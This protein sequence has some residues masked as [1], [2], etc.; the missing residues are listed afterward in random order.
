[1]V[2][3]HVSVLGVRDEPVLLRFLEGR[4]DTTMF[5]RANL[6]K[7]GI[8]DR[9]ARFQGTYVGA[10]RD[11]EIVGAASH[12]WNG[13]LLLEA[14][15]ALEE[16][17]RHAVRASR[18]DLRGLIGPWD[19]CLTAL[20]ALDAEDRPR[21]TFSREA[22]FA[23]DLSDLRVP[24]PLHAGEVQVRPATRADVGDFMTDWEVAYEVEALGTEPGDEL[25][26]QAQAS[27]EANLG[28]GWILEQAGRPV[29]MSSFNAALPDCV[30]I[31]GVFTPPEDRNRGFA[32]C[33]VAGS[34]LAAREQ[35][36]RRTILFTGDDN[37]AA[38]ACYRGLGYEQVGDYGIV[39]F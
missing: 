16:V 15:A 21:Q 26:A 37:P 12:C 9:G 10:W 38:Q 20:K 32:A 30:Q 2:D 6:R 27:L 18:H 5:L 1:M 23:L 31:G 35:G 29:S 17:V 11:G 7:A 33:T 39:L 28:N 24:R 19:Q 34:L 4:P 25:R 8:E 14:P 3:E 13:N 22:L 36:V